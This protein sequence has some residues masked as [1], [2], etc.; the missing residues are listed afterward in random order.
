MKMF[1]MVLVVGF[2]NVGFA[3]VSEPKILVKE[4]RIDKLINALIR[5]ESSGKDWEIGDNGLAYGCLQIHNGAVIDVNEMFKQNFTHQDAFNREKAIQICKLYFLRYGRSY[6]KR[7]GQKPDE[8]VLARIWN[9]GY[10]KYFKNKSATDGYWKKVK[11][12]LGF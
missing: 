10:G 9:G 11:K 6:E 8:E 5:V 2:F 1:F 12:E 7:T 4:T 3:N